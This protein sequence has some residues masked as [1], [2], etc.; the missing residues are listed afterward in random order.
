MIIKELEKQ[1]RIHPPKWLAVNVAYLGFAGSVAYGASSDTSD[2]DCFGF[3][4]PPKTILFPYSVGGE[5]V[6]FGRQHERFRVWSEHHIEVPDQRKSYDFSV[7]NVV[8]FFNL[9]MEN[10]PNILDVLF[11][12]RRC[13]LHTTPV[14]E[15]VRNQRKLFLHKG[16]MHR[17]RGYMFAQMNK[18]KNKTNASS[19]EVKDLR[20]YEA[21]HNIPHV[22]PYQDVL[23]EVTRRGL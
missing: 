7:Y 23:D 10:N 12:P 8:D 22:T 11:L 9:A 21:D 1:G 14:G 17:F 3:C 4:I 2:M 13:L 6:G 16:S 15:H 18:I 5:I 20:A 19:Q